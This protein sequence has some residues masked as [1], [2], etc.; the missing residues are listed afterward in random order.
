MIDFEY[1]SGRLA[2]EP[3]LRYTPS[4][5]PV[6]NFTLLQSSTYS[7]RAGQEH[8]NMSAVDV[9]I[10]SQKYGDSEIPWAI[11]AA[12]LLK[13]QHVVV[14][15]QYIQHKWQ[16]KQGENRYRMVFSARSVFLSLYAIE[17]VDTLPTPEH[18][19]RGSVT[20]EPPF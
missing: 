11:W 10:W 7:D 5:A 6:C 9:E 3:V 13:G 16:T 15:G 12:N 4:G 2:A 17:Q 18:S 14:H 19:T 8:K 1:R 20:D